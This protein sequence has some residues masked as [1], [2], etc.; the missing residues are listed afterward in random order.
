M[1]V[2]QPR[3]G[4]AGSWRLIGQTHANHTADHDVIVV[5]G[6]YDNF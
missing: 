2:T 4:P 3:P 6:R 5:Q 1:Q